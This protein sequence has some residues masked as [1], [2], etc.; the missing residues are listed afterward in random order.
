[1]ELPTEPTPGVFAFY[2]AFVKDHV[3]GGLVSP[4]VR[5][6]LQA[7]AT[8]EGKVGQVTLENIAD[9]EAFV[10]LLPYYLARER[11][12]LVSPGAA[13]CDR[14]WTRHG[15]PN[16]VPRLL[17]QKERCCD[18]LPW[19]PIVRSASNHSR[20]VEAPMLILNGNRRVALAGDSPRQLTIV[21]LAHAYSASTRAKIAEHFVADL[22]VFVSARPL[23]FLP[24]Y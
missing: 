10:A 4:P 7:T 11:V 14:A 22:V 5:A 17:G 24:I 23:D 3:D 1:M 21:E 20:T 8:F 18:L 6:A 13:A 16:F 12:F 19:C 2:H 9:S 15:G